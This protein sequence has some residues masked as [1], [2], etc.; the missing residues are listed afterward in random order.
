VT[1]KYGNYVRIFFLEN[2]MGV[3]IGDNNVIGIALKIKNFGST[4]ALK[5]T[6]WVC[7]AVRDIVV[8]KH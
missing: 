3:G 8:K 5:V 4:P 6:D 7:L 1:L 2:G